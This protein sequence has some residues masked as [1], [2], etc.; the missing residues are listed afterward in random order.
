MNDLQNSIESIIPVVTVDHMLLEF[1]H[2]IPN[3]LI[4]TIEILCKNENLPIIDVIPVGSA[5]RNTILPQKIEMD[6]FVRF[7]TRSQKILS[8][9]ADLVIEK[10]AEEFSCKYEIKY[11]ENPYGTLF[12]MANEFSITIPIDIVATIW[13]SEAKYLPDILK[14]SGMARTPFHMTFLK[15]FINQKE[16]E[17]KFFKYWCKKKFLYGQCGFTGFLCEL[18]IGRYETFE[19]LLKH[20]KEIAQIIW[21]PSYSQK[22]KNSL[23]ERFPNDLIIIID[24]IDQYRNTAAGIQ[25]FYGKLQLK[26]FISISQFNLSEHSNLWDEYQMTKPYFSVNVEF[27]PEVSNRNDE[28]II[29]RKI[30]MVNAINRQLEIE[31]NFVVEAIVT[32]EKMF[33]KTHRL[34]DITY[35]R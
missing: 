27:P 35:L 26:R 14:I 25:G 1:L 4:P 6:L 33:L 34:E 15:N 3:K 31:K 23:K 32:L 28:E 19:N 7:D 11:A 2:S 8:I 10:L 18:L 21:D 22:S 12:Y 20:S 9:F 24:P 16:L 29:S 17:V 13:I 30:S 5:F